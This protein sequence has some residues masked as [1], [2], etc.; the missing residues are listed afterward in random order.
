[1][2]GRNVVHAAFTLERTYPVPPARAFAAWATAEAKARWFSGP[3][4]WEEYERRLDF[5][6][7]GSERLHGRH[8]NGRVSDFD[9]RY[10]DVIPGERIV[11][12]YDM[13]SDG[14]KL[15]VSL[16]TIEFKPADGGTRL[17]MTEQGAFLDGY[18]DAGSR[19]HGTGVLLD[20]LGRALAAG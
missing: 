4:D 16:A 3:E 2:T 17:V 8:P 5:R 7:G 12:A 9:A 14:Q 10:F 19:E 11:Y 13:Y 18:D 1:M 15:S 6:P 20:R